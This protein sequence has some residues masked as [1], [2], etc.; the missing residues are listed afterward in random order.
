MII[1]WQ[2]RHL[3]LCF[4]TDPIYC[5]FLRRKKLLVSASASEKIGQC[6]AIPHGGGRSKKKEGGAE[7]DSHKQQERDRENLPVGER[8][9]APTKCWLSSCLTTIFGSP[10]FYRNFLRKCQMQTKRIHWAFDLIEFA[11]TAVHTFGHIS[12]RVD[13][14]KDT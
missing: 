5:H 3:V 12:V 9:A 1:F 14:K 6:Y 7:E 4:L 2:C 10:F 11:I 13:E 8:L